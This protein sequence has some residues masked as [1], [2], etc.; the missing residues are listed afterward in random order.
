MENKIVNYETIFIVDM[1]DGEEAVQAVVD[2]FK[3]LI[4]SAATIESVETWGKRR[5]A[6]PINDLTEGY[7]VLVNFQS[8]PEFPKELDR[9]YNINDAILRSIIIRKEA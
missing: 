9:I 7:Y 1:T 3:A 8:N 2:K 6:Y 5:L 4:E